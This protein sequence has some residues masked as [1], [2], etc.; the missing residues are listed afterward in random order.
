VFIKTSD[1]FFAEHDVIRE[2]GGRPIDLAFLDGMHRFAFALRDFINIERYCTPRSTCLLHD[3]YPL[4]AQTAAVERTTTFWSGDVWK[5]ILC[6]K[7]YRP[8]LAIHTVA[9]APTGLA[10]IRGLDPGSTIL[11]DQLDR[12]CQECAALPYAVLHDDKRRMLNLVANDWPTVQ[13]LLDEPVGQVDTIT[14]E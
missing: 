6:L 7:T 11:R 9:T 3:C 5:L 13:A 1:A 8:D 4:D 2:L 10:V 12:I 14:F